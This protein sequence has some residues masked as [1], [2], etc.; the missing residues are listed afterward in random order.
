MAKA[1]ETSFADISESIIK[2]YGE[3]AMP[4]SMLV[5]HTGE[6]ISSSLLG[7]DIGLNGGIREGTWVHIAA[8]PKTG[9]TSFCLGLAA[10]A[11]KMGKNVYWVDVEGRLQT[12]LLDCI[13]GLDK[14]KMQVIKSSIDKVLSAE[15][16][17][18]IIETLLTD[19]PGCVVFLDSLAVL[20]PEVELAAEMNEMQ[21]ATVP[22]LMYKFLRKISPILSTTK[23]NFVSI[24]HL[25]ANPSGYGSPFKEVGGYASNYGASYWMMGISSK[26]VE[27]G[28][29]NVGKDTTFRIMATSSGPP[30][31]EPVVPVR[32]GRGCDKY[33]D[34][35][36]IA[37]EMGF[38][39]KGGAWYEVLLEDFKKDGKYPKLQGEAN[40]VKYLE[41]N[42]D[43]F[44]ML[45]KN[46][47]TLVFGNKKREKK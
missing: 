28:G 46:I 24:T 23:S 19:D 27:V 5:E 11:Q 9:K 17:L 2:K 3:I 42:K 12:E 20:C 6:Y 41:D 16:Y 18:S 35:A 39:K 47:R 21:R 8:L 1:I 44:D 10:S 26:K 15:D 4:A 31:A 34:M 29:K 45:D 30:D 32:Y 33:A 22:K 13:D 38:V 7:M 43:A 25:Q 14:E 36:R 40:L 37:E